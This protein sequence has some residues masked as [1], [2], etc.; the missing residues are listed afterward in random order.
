MDG[1]IAA[2]FAAGLLGSVHCAS[3]CGGIAAALTAASRGHPVP[4]QVAFNAG[5]IASYAAAGAVV[6]F[7]GNAAVLAGSWFG[8][9][10]VLFIA[11]NVLMIFLGLYIAGWG[12]RL[13]RLEFAGRLLWKR[14]EPLRRRFF[15]IDSTPRALGAG[16]VWGWI[17][18][19]L[20]YGMLAMAM[21][22]GR[23]GQGAL[24]MLAFGAGTLPSMLTAGFAADR[25]FHLRKH[26][27]VRKGAGI[28]IIALAAFGLARVPYL[29]ELLQR[30][31]QCIA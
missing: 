23:P 6:G 1:L 17:P 3:M 4:R 18:C 2:A 8:A 16:A 7:F 14:I 28:A 9:Q 31:W 13:I 25:I 27:L 19:G 29:H 30:G 22:S 24:V 12:G 26:P 5:R 21:A 20:V 11:A 15:P 10:T